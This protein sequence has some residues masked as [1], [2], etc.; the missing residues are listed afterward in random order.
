MKPTAPPRTINGPP[1][2]FLCRNVAL[3]RPGPRPPDFLGFDLT[4]AAIQLTNNVTNSWVIIFS[5]LNLNTNTMTIT[6]WIHPLGVQADS[7]GCSSA[8]RNHRGRLNYGSVGSG[9]AQ[10]L[11]TPGIMT[12]H[13]GMELAPAAP[14]NRWSFVALVVQPASAILYLA[15]TD[16]IQSATNVL[17][18]PNQAFASVSVI[19]T[20]PLP[21]TPACSTAGSMKSPCSIVRSPRRR[22]RRSMQTVAGCPKSRSAS[23]RPAA[24]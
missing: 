20:D 14:P 8:A 11:G 7:A 2:R 24:I 17:N 16:R 5:G 10:T 15:N 6:A 13:V 4:N 3:G 19:G 9:N 22:S 18:H 21:E 23:S 1:P 12:P